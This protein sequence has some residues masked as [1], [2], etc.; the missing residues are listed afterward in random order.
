MLKKII[1]ITLILFLTSCAHMQNQQHATNYKDHSS[2]RVRGKTYYI[3]KSSKNFHETGVA[4]WYGRGFH[5]HKTN[6]GERY[7]MY[8]LT[9]AHKTLPLQTR[10]LVTNLSNGKQ[11]TVRINDRGPFSG[12]RIIDLSYAAAKKLNMVNR[13]MVRVSVRALS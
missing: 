8:Q 13:G 9:A 10:V 11:V 1:I 2:Y 5:R 12:K 6:S 7:N 3:M 4:S